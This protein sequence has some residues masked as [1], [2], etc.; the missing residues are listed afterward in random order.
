MGGAGSLGFPCGVC[1][2]ESDPATSPEPDLPAQGRGP[3]SCA[4]PRSGNYCQ[5]SP[6]LLG[7]NLHAAGDPQTRHISG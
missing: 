1:T 4:H 6:L 2:I 7:F 3:L 5:Q